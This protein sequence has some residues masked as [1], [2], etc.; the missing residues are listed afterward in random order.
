MFEEEEKST[1]PV[2]SLR[3]AGQGGI[4]EKIPDGTLIESR[5]RKSEQ[6]DK[7]SFCLTAG[8]I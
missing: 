1:Q 4:N 3:V 7:W 8:K 5:L 2:M 6:S